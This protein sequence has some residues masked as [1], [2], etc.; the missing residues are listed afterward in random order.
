ME[1]MKRMAGALA[2]RYVLALVALLLAA[3]AVWFV[4]PL[5]AFGGMQPLAGAGMRVTVILLLLGLVV[6]LLRGFTVSVVGMVALCLLIWH[7]GPLFAFGERRPLAP[8]EVRV[9]LISV[10][11]LGFIAYWLFLIWRKAQAE[12]HFVRMLLSFGKG[13][14]EQVAKAEIAQLNDVIL[15]ALAQ[16][17]GMRTGSGLGRLFEGRRYLY[18]LPWYMTVGAAGVGKTTALLNAGLQFPLAGQMGKAAGARSGT[19]FTDW[20][21]TNEA[22]L[23]DTAG[24]YT[25]QASSPDLDAAEWKG[26]LG[27]LKRYRARAPVNGVLVTISAQ[28]L[29]SNSAEEAALEAAAIR[30]R[31]EDLRQDL[32]IRF[33]IYVVVTK[34]DTI[35]GFEPYF[36]ALTSEAKSQ[37]WGFT[38]PY[39]NKGGRREDAQDLAAQCRAQM[40]ALVRRV[41]GTVDRRLLETFDAQQMQAMHSLVE[42]FSFLAVPAMEMV[43]RIFLDSRFDGTQHKPMLRGVYFTSAAQTG[44]VALADTDH[45][46]HRLLS[47]TG[48]SEQAAGAA[49]A[50]A[51]AREAAISRIVT[52]NSSYFL[53]DVFHRV[54]VPEAHLVRPN[55]RWEFRFR[56]MRTVAHVMGALLAVWL[57]AAFVESTRRNSDYLHVVADKARALITQYVAYVKAPRAESMPAVLAAGSELAAYPGLVLSE[58]ALPWRYG[59]Y[60]A[61]LPVAAASQVHARLQDRLLVPHM[62]KRIEAVLQTAVAQ[63]DAKRTY[64]TLR[65][66]LLLHE[67]D[68][69][70]ARDVWH[71]VQDDWAKGGGAEAAGGRVAILGQLEA[72]LDGSRS[73][74]ANSARNEE[75]IRSARAFLDGN[76]STE[77]LYER[78]K[79]AM[80]AEA[81]Q[82]F[83]LMRAVG[84]QAG[85]LFVR[86]SDEPLERGVAGLFTYAGYHELFNA[87]LPEFVAVAQALDAWVMGRE[88]RPSAQKKTLEGM[89][90]GLAGNDPLTQEIR[91]LY[92]NEYASRWEAFLGDIRVVTGNNLAFDLEILRNF[93]APDSPLARLGRAVVRETTLSQ[94]L[95]PEDKSL[96]DKALSAVERKTGLGGLAARAEGRQ[97]REA[98]DNRF[99]ALR[100]VVTGQADTQKAGAAAQAAAGKPQL[101][102]I[103]GMVNAYYTTLVVASNALQ[104]RNLPPPSEAGAQLRMEAAKLPAPF[105]AVLND[106]VVQGTRA[107]NKG[108]GD[109]LV[110]RMDA[111]IG[112]SCR[113]AIDGKYPFSPGSAR[114]VDPDDFARIFAAGG[115]L[116]DFFQ[117]VLAPHVDTTISPWRY[118]LS[119]P[120]VPPLAGPSLVPFQRA[121]AIREVFFREPGAS[122]MAWKVDLKV[123][124]LDPEI[125]ELNLDFDGQSQRYVHGPVV[126]L[127]VSWPGPRGG[128][129][130]ELAASPK[131]RPETSTLSASGP[132]ALMRV[133]AKGKLAGSASASHFSAEYDFDGRKA[134]LDINT[135]SLANPWTTGLLQGFQCPAR[136][137]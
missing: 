17:R 105:K 30:A 59:M 130:A 18:E 93:A 120:D 32:G 109:I 83:T 56:L 6:C 66:Y 81:P 41:E 29:L 45:L 76:T 57:L 62:V 10:I 67:K 115:V 133:I 55:L 23:I 33:P 124:A 58:P 49:D 78:A 26:F 112:E 37:P 121:K 79:A 131:I 87:R 128:H 73:V 77:R 40:E 3:A 11:A 64:D 44:E 97:E 99:A 80:A 25:S 38:L 42:D 101:D 68:K 15:A 107:V 65:V 63:R 136:S 24:R 39:G 35:P 119:A 1:F 47:A 102:A 116:D 70:N 5:L 9:T 71:W 50:G 96:A 95:E 84:P 22:V 52:G 126:P 28:D 127:K 75:L 114:D 12:E 108:A 92:L 4:G 137:G 90:G 51:D 19:A 135:G 36:R 61:P 46:I 117:K 104:T 98:V 14:K 2:S 43:E 13:S 54:V 8:V 7:A 122:R 74:Q 20:W 111:V 113:S 53:R 31:L 48:S 94:A 132:W 60:A 69:F 134:T 85:T 129:G 100:E 89:S 123:V 125:V 91:R 106:L 82:D 110:A 34:L 21:F 72:L 118:T 16:L 88:A 103:A 27:L 86:A